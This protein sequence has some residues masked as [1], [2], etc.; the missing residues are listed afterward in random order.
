MNKKNII[1][2]ISVLVLIFVGFFV[3]NNTSLKTNDKD[4]N[5]NKQKGSV[6]DASYTY[7]VKLRRC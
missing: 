3:Y 5:E 7:K 2:T 1:I 4:T 6:Y